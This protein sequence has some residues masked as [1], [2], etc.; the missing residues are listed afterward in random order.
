MKQFLKK[1]SL[2]LKICMSVTSSFSSG[3]SPTALFLRPPKL[4]DLWNIYASGLLLVWKGLA[5]EYCC[6]YQKMWVFWIPLKIKWLKNCK[7]RMNRFIKH[8]VNKKGCYQAEQELMLFLK[9]SKSGIP[10]ISAW[11]SLFMAFDMNELLRGEVQKNGIIWE[12]FPSVRSPL[13]P[14]WEMTW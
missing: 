6:L 8:I 3:A 14:F 12:Y 11:V 4:P 5:T 7:S 13:P 2:A 9:P 10:A 1:K